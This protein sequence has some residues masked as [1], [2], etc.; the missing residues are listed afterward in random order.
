MQLDSLES[1]DP[2]EVQDILWRDW[3][4]A[5]GWDVGANAGQSVPWMLDRF[6]LVHCFEPSE[7]ARAVFEGVWPTELR[8]G[9]VKLYPCALAAH[10]GQLAVAVREAPIQSGQLVAVD[11]PYHGEDRGP[12]TA[13]WGRDKYTWQVDCTTADDIAD[14]KGIPD[15]VKVDTE[16][17]ELLVLQGAAQILSKRLTGWLVEYHTAGLAAQCVALLQAAGY[18]LEMVA[19]PRYEPGSDM[20]YQHGWIRAAP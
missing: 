12:N 13:V 4:G 18:R 11:M 10:T 1:S 8:S 20:W 9:R 19:N 14:R 17:H 15:F 3:H 2:P 7:A 6:G 5:I 16:G